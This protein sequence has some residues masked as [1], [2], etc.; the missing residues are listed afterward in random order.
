MIA[1]GP[2]VA[3]GPAA[4]VELGN[5]TG[6]ATELEVDGAGAAGLSVLEPSQ[7]S[8]VTKLRATTANARTLVR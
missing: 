2:R 7:A 8:I 6:E 5:E 1:F 3:G 4:V